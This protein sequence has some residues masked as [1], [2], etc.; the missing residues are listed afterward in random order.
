MQKLNKFVCA[1]GLA[2]ASSAPLFAQE[3]PQL[4]LQK[5]PSVFDHLDLSVNLGSTG[6]GVDLAAPIGDYVQV[7][8]GF[9]Y[10]PRF[11]YNMNFEI[12]VGD[13]YSTEDAIAEH[14][15]FNR[16]ANMLEQLTGYRVNKYVDMIGEPTFNNL[17]FMVDVLPFK[18]NKHW[19]FT[20]GFY[21]GSSKIAKAYNAT[22]E[23]PSLMAVAIYN[24][25]YDKIASG[26]GII[27]NIGG[28]QIPMFNDPELEDKILENGRMGMYVG[29]YKHDNKP[30]MMEPDK[31]NMAKAVIKVNP[32]RPYLGF[33]YGGR[34]MKDSD[35]YH[36]SFDCGMMM[37]GG[38]PHILT[39]D[40]TNLSKDVTNIVGNVG[41]YVK[42]IKVFKAYPVLQVRV[43]QRLF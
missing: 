7:R 20:A 43:T 40:G 29:D 35:K 15:R 16:L 3:T 32:F 39:H 24:N 23:M 13:V 2:L 31:D 37:W 30:Y 12:Q 18:R 36:I 1:L 41:S 5:K 42:T 9:D 26:E 34:L 4:S 19:H 10:L 21:F 38:T 33:G 28:M 22:E 25:M 11:H 17:K 6:V 27:L 8:A 14:E